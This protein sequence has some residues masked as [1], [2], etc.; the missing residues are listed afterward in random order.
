V[1]T[2]WGPPGPEDLPEPETVRSPARARAEDLAADGAR[3]GHQLGIDCRP[4][5]RRHRTTVAEAIVAEARRAD[6]HAIIVGRGGRTGTEPL[7]S[8]SRAVVRDADCAVPLAAAAAHGAA[9]QG[10]AGELGAA[11]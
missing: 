1:L 9:S 8:V 6:A 2:V 4:G 3:L 11:A 5:T 10:D 7:G